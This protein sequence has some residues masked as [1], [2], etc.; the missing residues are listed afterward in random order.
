MNSN[1][2]TGPE[3]LETEMT[4]HAYHN[5]IIRSFHK[6]LQNSA[7]RA[8][9]LHRK[10]NTDVILLCVKADDETNFELARLVAPEIMNHNNL[11]DSTPFA[12]G[13]ISWSICEDMAVRQHEQSKQILAIP[14]ENTYKLLL[15]ACGSMSIYNVIPKQSDIIH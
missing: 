4:V 5:S 2:I 13:I 6:K 10:K 1:L 12:T 9:N 11:D 7:W 3:R 15:L 14:P 8:Q